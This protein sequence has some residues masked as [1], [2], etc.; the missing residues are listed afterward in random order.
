VPDLCEGP[1]RD[2]AAVHRDRRHA[3]ATADCEV[4]PGL[5]H[6]GAAPLAQEPADLAYCHTLSLADIDTMRLL[7]LAI[8]R[9]GWTEVTS[10]K[11]SPGRR[12][13]QMN[14]YGAQPSVSTKYLVKGQN[15]GYANGEN[16]RGVRQ[17]IQL[18]GSPG[19]RDAAGPCRSAV[20]TQALRA[21]RLVLGVQR[22]ATEPCS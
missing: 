1:G 14:H 12:L 18:S 20:G 6:L 11:L 15:D 16:V 21:S 2:V 19:S 5:A 17:N 9:Q 10:A 7:T 8:G 13:R 22:A 3:F 4:G